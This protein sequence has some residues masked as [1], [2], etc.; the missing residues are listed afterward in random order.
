VTQSASPLLTVSNLSVE[1]ER[2]HGRASVLAVDGVSFAVDAGE[3]VGLV[4]ESGSGKSSVARAILG[5]AAV[6]SGSV[7]FEGD[8]IANATYRARRML[9][10]HLQVVFQD[11]YAS[12]NPARTVGKSLAETVRASPGLD[13]RAVEQ[14][15]AT[16]LVRVGLP[17][18]A[19][20]RYPTQ[21]S[22]GQRQRI[23]IARALM[24]WPKLVICDEPVSALD[25]S[26]QAQ[27][28]NLLRDLQRELSL[29][30]L[31]ISHD[32]AVVRYVSQRILVLYGGRVMEYGEAAGVYAAPAHP[33]TRTLLAAAAF[34]DPAVRRTPHPPTS[35]SLRPGPQP[36]SA[37][38][39]SC[40][41]ADRCR[42]AIE[43]CRSRRPRLESRPDGRLLACHRWR[44]LGAEGVPNHPPFATTDDRHDFAL[45]ATSAAGGPGAVGPRAGSAH[46]RGLS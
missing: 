27:I 42:Y 44:D 24:G 43:E 1:Y 38:P 8:E 13:K 31:F 40:V 9:A 37:S 23:A 45:R 6:T 35:K 19:A 5:L 7:K 22:G 39:D 30:Y 18:E 33:Y 14:R 17:A 16:A 12:L 29:S 11:P 2:R 46:C 28:L 4:G 34:P 26:I 21:F 41:F 10:R 20:K 36:G 32:L 15:V 3:T 25:L